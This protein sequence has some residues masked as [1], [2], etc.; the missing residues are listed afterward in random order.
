MWSLLRL[1][2]LLDS[3]FGF[4]LCS[5]FH[6]LVLLDPHSSAYAAEYVRTTHCI[7]HTAQFSSWL[8]LYSLCLG[9]FA[10]AHGVRLDARSLR[11]SRTSRAQGCY[12]H[13]LFCV[14]AVPTILHLQ[15]ASLSTC[16]FL[17]TATFLISISANFFHNLPSC[18]TFLHFSGHSFCRISVFFISSVINFQFWERTVIFVLF[19]LFGSTCPSICSLEFNILLYLPT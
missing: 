1:L 7:F 4:L 13:L 14:E 9:V 15:H 11:T 18:A 10:S 17:R 5:I 3:T 2:S 8:A 19:S 12:S 16:S 6:G